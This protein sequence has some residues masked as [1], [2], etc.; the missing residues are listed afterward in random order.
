VPFLSRQ[1]ISPELRAKY[2]G[3]YKAQLREA[4][5]NPNLSAEAREHLRQQVKAVGEAKVYT[6]DAPPKPGAL[7]FP[8]WPD[9][10]EVR[11]MKKAGLVQLAQQMGVDDTGNKPDVLK[12]VLAVV[13]R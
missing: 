6:A 12:R 9:P 8:K 1:E 11:H 2:E 3:R 10:S 7:S 4:L 5:H 13:G